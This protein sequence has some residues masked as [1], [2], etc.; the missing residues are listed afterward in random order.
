[1]RLQYSPFLSSYR[2]S[3]PVYIWIITQVTVW[4]GFT[5]SYASRLNA[6]SA[7][8]TIFKHLEI[9]GVCQIRATEAQYDFR[10]MYDP[11]IQP[12]ISSI[13]EQTFPNMCFSKEGT[14]LWKSSNCMIYK[15]NKYQ[16]YHQ[17]KHVCLMV[18]LKSWRPKD[19][20]IQSRAGTKAS[21][22]TFKVRAFFIHYRS[23]FL[24][25]YAKGSSKTCN[26]AACLWAKLFCLLSCIFLPF[27]LASK[28]SKYHASL[29]RYIL[30]DR[31]R[32]F[33]ASST[34]TLRE[35]HFCSTILSLPNCLVDFK[36]QHGCFSEAFPVTSA[37][38]MQKG[39]R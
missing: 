27:L 12:D 9:P 19:V 33:A 34:A 25:N 22:W 35:W 3:L 32:S 28:V 6:I 8:I 2:I 31:D 30:L 1:M 26:L 15:S 21:L 4:N 11:Y 13:S 5:K 14:N 17:G 20:L 38:Y 29:L 23:I 10:D 36:I 16:P 18:S 24:T 37:L 7:E 39:V